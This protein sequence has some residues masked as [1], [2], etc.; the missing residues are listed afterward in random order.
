MSETIER[1]VDIIESGILSTCL[2]CFVAVELR[3]GY[4]PMPNEEQ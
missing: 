3:I 2:F 4:V 1:I